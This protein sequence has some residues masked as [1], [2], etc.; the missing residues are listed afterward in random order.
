MKVHQRDSRTRE[1]S[2]WGKNTAFL[3][4]MR[5]SWGVLF[6]PKYDPCFGNLL[7]AHTVFSSVGWMN[8]LLRSI[9]FLQIFSL[10]KKR[11]SFLNVIFYTTYVWL[12]WIN[13]IWHGMQTASAYD[14]PFEK[15][16]QTEMV[17]ISSFC[18]LFSHYAFPN[19]FVPSHCWSVIL[20]YVVNACFFF[21]WSFSL[22]FPVLGKMSHL[23][24]Q[25]S[26]LWWNESS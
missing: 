3:L 25:N 12:N 22:I 5:I 23:I 8:S 16:K 9:S 15:N 2:L 21:N 18:Y 13:I 1:A 6:N 20:Q 26:N 17:W 7:T 14:H 4:C 24:R 10:T 19:Y 11:K